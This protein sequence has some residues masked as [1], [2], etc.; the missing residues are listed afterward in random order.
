MKASR[1]HK[2]SVAAVVAL[3]FC[4]PAAAVDYWVVANTLSSH[5]ERQCPACEG[6]TPNEF[7]W[8]GGLEARFK[9]NLAAQVGGYRNTYGH[10]TAY[11]IG[12]WQPITD[13][14]MS[15]GGFV[16]AAT[17][18]KSDPGCQRDVCPVGGFLISFSGERYGF[19]VMVVPA[20]SGTT[21]NVFGLQLKLK[22]N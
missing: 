3:A 1:F 17:G 22:L 10:G 5:S 7:N 13:G 6:G 18:Y 11:A 19:N 21:T 9:H 12:I 2:L 4:A 15:A 20:I 14:R 16:G 8:G